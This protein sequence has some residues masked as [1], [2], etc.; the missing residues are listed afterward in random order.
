MTPL[1]SQRTRRKPLKNRLTAVGALLALAATACGCAVH[2][3]GASARPQSAPDITA[4]TAA[5]ALDA[6][7]TQPVKGRAPKTGYDRTG[8][9][10]PAWSDRT[11]AP[12]ARNSCDTRD[13]VLICDLHDVRFRAGSRCIVV[14]GTLSDPYTGQDTAF[15]RGPRTSLAVQIDHVVALSDAWQ[16]GAQTLT[17]AQREALANDPLELVAASGPANTHKS[18]ADA[19]SWL[20]ANK[21]YRCAYVARQ[22]AVKAK[23]RLLVTL[24]EHTAM[25]RVLNTC[26]GQ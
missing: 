6:L 26:P 5:P 23:Y 20:P 22:I 11:T 1:P 13:D 14:S 17:Q 7:R 8:K 4:R 18:D 12:G 15:T 3:P 21:T 10:G 19:A 2:L 24:A 9:F 16:T 25:T